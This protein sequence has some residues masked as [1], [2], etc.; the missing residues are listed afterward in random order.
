MVLL[1]QCSD[2]NT[3]ISGILQGLVLGSLL[4]LIYINDIND[5]TSKILKFLAD[6]KL[7]CV[8]A[9]KTHILKLQSDLKSVCK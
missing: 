8:L 1:G 9:N 2:C 5:V 4:L 7:F 3:V 6:T